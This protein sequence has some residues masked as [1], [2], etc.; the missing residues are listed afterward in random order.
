MAKIDSDEFLSEILTAKR[1][2][3]SNN[4]LKESSLESDDLEKL[5]IPKKI[6]DEYRLIKKFKKIQNYNISDKLKEILY[7]E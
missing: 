6:I 7:Q 5:S 4:F 3:H 1:S 2:N